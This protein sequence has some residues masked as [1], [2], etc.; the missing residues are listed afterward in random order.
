M[1]CVEVAHVLTTTLLELEWETNIHLGTCSIRTKWRNRTLQTTS[2]EA[3]RPLECWLVLE[4]ELHLFV[5]RPFLSSDLNVW[6]REALVVTC[7]GYG[8]SLV[9]CSSALVTCNGAGGLL[10]HPTQVKLWAQ[11]EVGKLVGWFNTPI[12]VKSNYKWRKSR[13]WVYVLSCWVYHQLL[14]IWWFCHLH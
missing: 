7:S 8:L 12:Q 1:A 10:L 2:M 6:T 13:H 9:V 11:S 4:H 5:Q 14:C 3:G